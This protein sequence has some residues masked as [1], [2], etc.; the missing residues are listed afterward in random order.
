L[1]LYYYFLNHTDETYA[2]SLAFTALV[3][4]QLFRGFGARSRQ[5]IFWQLGVFS[6]LWLLAVTLVTAALQVS[7]HYIPFTQELF[8]LSPLTTGDLLL[9]LPF[10]LL[11]VSVLEITKLLR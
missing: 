2:R 1:A 5:R 6:N 9:V 3:F 10:A 4:S 8:G 7:L 11:P